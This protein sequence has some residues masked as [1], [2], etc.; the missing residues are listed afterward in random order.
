MQQYQ[1]LSRQKLAATINN[2]QCLSRVNFESQNALLVSHMLQTHME[3]A[4]RKPK[5]VLRMRLNLTMQLLTTDS[6]CRKL[7][8]KG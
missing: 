2:L 5:C 4:Q 1:R 7:K 6:N 3:S 8:Q